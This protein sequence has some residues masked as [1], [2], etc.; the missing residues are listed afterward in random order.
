[1]HPV[2]CQWSRRSRKILCKRL[3][4][5]GIEYRRDFPSPP[6]P[7]SENTS[8][9]DHFLASAAP[10]L[11]GWTKEELGKETSRLLRAVW[12][13]KKVPINGKRQGE[14]RYYPPIPSSFPR[15]RSTQFPSSMRK[16]KGD[17]E[18]WNRL[19]QIAGIHLKR[20]KGGKSR[21]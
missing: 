5:L 12:K 9:N 8:L 19:C 4:V 16:V 15:S 20:G 7:C 14:M 6:L 2:D 11:F 1:M 10:L 3:L 18:S 13:K 21:N 17:S